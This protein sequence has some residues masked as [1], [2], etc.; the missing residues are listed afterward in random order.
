MPIFSYLATPKDG[1]RETLCADLTAL[2]HCQIIP[3]DNH[4]LIVLITD[5][6]NETTEETLQESLKNL[7]SLQSLDLAFGYDESFNE[8][9]DEN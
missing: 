1:A 8:S 5:T 2:A 4:E 6:P 7:Q 9:Y 3:A